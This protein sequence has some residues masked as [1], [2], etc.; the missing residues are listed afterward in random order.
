MRR[1]RVPLAELLGVNVLRCGIHFGPKK[2]G[3][4][5]VCLRV[6]TEMRE[7]I[8]ARWLLM[9]GS[10]RAADLRRQALFRAGKKS[11]RKVTDAQRLK[12]AGRVL[13]PR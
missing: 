6:Q 5:S 7:E 1:K 4:C 3:P 11:L 9:S 10:V 8:T 12:S 13:V 2:R